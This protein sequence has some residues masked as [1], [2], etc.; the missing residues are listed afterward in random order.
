LSGYE[1]GTEELLRAMQTLTD[2]FGLDSIRVAVRVQD[3]HLISLTL[4][5]GAP[6]V[7]EREDGISAIVRD[8]A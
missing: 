3:D 6:L 2:E 4:S 7:I 1:T 5:K 8:F